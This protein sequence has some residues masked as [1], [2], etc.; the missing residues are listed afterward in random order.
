MIRVALKR[1]MDNYLSNYE[2]PNEIEIARL[3]DDS[4]SINGFWSHEE[5]EANV[6]LVLTTAYDDYADFI[7]AFEI[8]DDIQRS[9]DK[10]TFEKLMSLYQAGKGAISCS[11]EGAN[12]P[13]LEFYIRDHTMVAKDDVDTFH[14]VG[15]VL[16]TPAD[17][18]AYT[19]RY[20]EL[21]K[22][23]RGFAAVKHFSLQFP[24]QVEN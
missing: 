19:K 16:E 10:I 5:S 23:L 8:T 2:N 7:E 17:F 6:E 1:F 11:I 22:H 14:E 18:V 13:S 15:N 9:L 24:V 12:A 3:T 4:F 21:N 20:F